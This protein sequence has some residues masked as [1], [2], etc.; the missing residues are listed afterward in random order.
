MTATPE[1][2]GPP[3]VTGGD[4]QQSTILVFDPDGLA[5]HGELPAT[6]R[7]LTERYRI[8]WCRVPADGALTEASEL[9]SDDGG[10]TAPVYVLASG[11]ATYPV[12]RLLAEHP[13]RAEALLLVDPPDDAADQGRVIARSE[14]GPRDRIP[15]PLPLGHPDVVAAL[16]RAIS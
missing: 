2:E 1:A 11:R 9:L 6:W 8:I 12:Q 3:I 16:E 13:D 14:G 4:P 5:K 10:T 7:P 15:P